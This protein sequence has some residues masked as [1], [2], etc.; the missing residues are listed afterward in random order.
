MSRTRQQRRS[1]KSSRPRSWACHHAT[2]PPPN[3]SPEPTVSTTRTDGTGSVVGGRS[4]AM[5]WTACGPSVRTTTVGPWSSIARAAR[6]GSTPGA[7]TARSS[8]VTRMIDARAAMR[9]T[10]FRHPPRS[11]V[12]DGRAFGSSISHVAAGSASTSASRLVAMGSNTSPSVPRWSAQGDV[13]SARPAI[14]AVSSGAAVP[15]T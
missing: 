12:A 4:R 10:R 8:V 14:P 9:V 11:G 13:S 1:P 3:A 2:S 15:S 6:T 7:R 5:I